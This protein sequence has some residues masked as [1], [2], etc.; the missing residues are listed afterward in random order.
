MTVVPPDPDDTSWLEDHI[1][2]LMERGWWPQPQRRRRH[3][4]AM[5]LTAATTLL[6]L[7]FVSGLAMPRAYSVRVGTLPAGCQG[8]ANTPGGADPFGGCWPGAWNTGVPTGTSL[9]SYSGS[10]QITTD[11]TV[12]TAKIVTCQPL[13]IRASNVQI[14]NS[15]TE[16]IWLDT[17][18]NGASAWSVS[19]TDSEV[20][21]S[22]LMNLASVCCGDYTLTRV[23]VQGGDYSTQCEMGTTFGTNGVNCTITDSYLH[24]QIIDTAGNWHAGGFISEGGPN[25]LDLGHNF[26]YCDVPTNAPPFEDGGCTGDMNLLGWFGTL[27]DATIHNN[28]FGAT[29][30]D[31]NGGPKTA[32]FCTYGGVVATPGGSPPTQRVKFLNNVYKK[33]PSGV[34][35]GTGP[36]TNFDSTGTGNEWTNN[37]YDDGTTIPTP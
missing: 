5:R 36:I 25:V 31:R 1:A 3:G 22:R 28:L 8:A 35:G 19:L 29:S 23:E 30:T 37:V 7:A 20:T 11:N 4:L 13:E 17:D 12:I 15:Q 2:W 10:C 27:Q 9:T 34:C 32:E 26:I 18:L 33:G 21:V 14:V 6:T 16:Q 24:G